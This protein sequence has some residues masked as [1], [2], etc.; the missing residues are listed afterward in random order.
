[1][2]ATSR[3]LRSLV[4]I[5]AAAIAVSTAAPAAAQNNA[6]VF[7]VITDAAGQPVED[8]TVTLVYEGGLARSYE[9]TTNADGEF[10]QMGLVRGPYTLTAV[11]EGVG[12]NRAA[13]DLRAGESV[14]RD[15]TL[16]SLEEVYRE[17]VSEEERAALDARAATTDAF[18]QGLAAAR[19][20]NLEAAVTLFRAALESTPNCAECQRNLG[21]VQ[22]R[23]GA[24]DEAEAAFRAALA[25][26]PEN[27]ASYDGLA[28][29]YN[30]QRRFDEAAEASAASARLSGGSAG[31]GDDPTAVFDQGLIFWNAGRL[32]EA[33]QQFERTLQLDPEHGEAHYWLGMANLNAGQMTEA[34]AEFRIYLDR[35]PNGRFAATATGILSSIQP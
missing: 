5:V 32:D 9:V 26:D 19:G 18:E 16:R 10:L 22:G 2:F 24:Y 27:A 20:G 6:R 33:R 15:L 29:I 7:G 28:E 31:A 34:A 13:I 35:E 23:L 8:V 12:I 4:P 11:K 30:A 1:M 21:L 25:L 14:E 3:L 17:S